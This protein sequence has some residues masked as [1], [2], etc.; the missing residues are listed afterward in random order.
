MKQSCPREEGLPSQKSQ[1]YRGF[2]E[3]LYDKMFVIDFQTPSTVHAK[4]NQ[5][6]LIEIFC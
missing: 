5:S 4:N 1:L 2:I 6:I 3:R